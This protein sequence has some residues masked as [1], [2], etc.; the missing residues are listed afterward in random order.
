MEEST[1]EPEQECQTCRFWERDYGNFMYGKCHIRSPL[2]NRTWPTTAESNWC[3]EHEERKGQTMTTSGHIF[4]DGTCIGCQMPL[5][6]YRRQ[7]GGSLRGGSTCGEWRLIQ[8][9][10]REAV[11]LKDRKER[12]PHQI[13]EEWYRIE[14]IHRSTSKSSDIPQ[15]TRS[16]EFA[17]WLCNEY[18]LAMAKGIRIGQGDKSV[19]LDELTEEAQRLGMGY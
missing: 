18:R 9:Q 10:I 13:A 19:F 12:T 1:E 16:R 14:S 7:T 8:E 3:G 17:E 11:R 4:V 15:D 2:T 6:A 5:D